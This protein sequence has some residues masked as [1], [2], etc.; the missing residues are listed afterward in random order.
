MMFVGNFSFTSSILESLANS[1]L[2]NPFEEINVLW[3]EY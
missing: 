1:V 3:I 2:I